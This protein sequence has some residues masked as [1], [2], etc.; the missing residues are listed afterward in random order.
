MKKI[1]FSIVVLS[2]V[3]S[4]NRNKPKIEATK[5]QA[6]LTDVHYAEAYSMITQKDSSLRGNKKNID[7]LA[8]FYALIFKHHHI[9]SKDYF[10][11]LEWY[12]AHPNELDSVYLKMIPEFTKEEDIYR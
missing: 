7:S 4:C 12:K 6:V 2:M 9:S 3:F 5:M 8:S 1:F 11:S 10:Q